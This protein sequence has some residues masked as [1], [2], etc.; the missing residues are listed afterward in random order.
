MFGLGF[1]ILAYAS[2]WY[3]DHKQA[4]LIKTNKVA[5]REVYENQVTFN[6]ISLLIN[7]AESLESVSVIESL[8][9]GI[10]KQNKDKLSPYVYLKKASLLFNQ[11]EYYLKRASE[12]ESSVGVQKSADP[13]E[14]DP[15][16]PGAEPMQAPQQ[17]HPL[18]IEALKKATDLYEEARKEIDKLTENDDPEFNYG[19]NYL[20]GE[21][22]YRFLEFLSDNDTVQELFNQ[23]LNYFKIA[24]RYRPGDINTVV[25]IELLI[26]NQSQ[27]LANANNPQGRRKQ[28]L[29]VRRAGFGNSRGN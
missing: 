7:K 8:M 6:D 10:S 1:I 13:P 5:A 3:L 2:Y 22:Y 19:L 12:I 20:K 25:N 16:N 18:T 29:N 26:K 11:G 14:I 28:M 9:T 4:Q 23:A 27:M 17:Y 21:I 24:L 15:E